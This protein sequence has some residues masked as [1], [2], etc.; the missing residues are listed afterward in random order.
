M[1][2]IERIQSLSVKVEQQKGSIETEEATK[3]AFIM[4]FIAALGYDVFN[5]TE[6]VPEFT[7]DIGV[8]K[9][10]KVDYAI[11]QDGAPIILIE[12]K[13][14]NC[15]LGSVHA[16]QLQRYFTV[17]DARF[18]ILTN[19]IVYRFFTD[20]DKAN[21]MDERPFL[22]F[23]ILDVRDRQVN[24]LKK[25]TKSAFDVDH[26]M[27]TASQLKYTNAIKQIMEQ[28]TIEPEEEFV[29]FFAGKVYSG[30]LS[31]S[32]KEQFADITKLALRQFI[33]DKIK[34]RL[35]SATALVE[36]P[37]EP[38]IEAEDEEG[39]AIITTESE[40]TG[41]LIVRAILSEII[42]PER[43]CMRDTQSYCGIL[44]DD[45]NRK[46]ICRLHFN[47]AQKYLGLID[48][49][50]NEERVPIDKVLDIYKY[51]AHLK[52]TVGYYND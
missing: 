44:L 23:N 18:S 9:G 30:R 4:P 47:R 19:G 25:F 24:E 28:Q 41:H 2:F 36:E 51:S 48:Q 50:K 8:K 12:A 26:I 43:V 35:E 31:T 33:N 20:L 16:S 29:R 17:T 37:P 11:M 3:T 42:D 21:I 46:P 34:E 5:P 40:V 49:E 15:E 52:E 27:T 1:D 22:E 32:V 45:N 38:E 14:A 13:S 6:V 10:E 39:T 7:A